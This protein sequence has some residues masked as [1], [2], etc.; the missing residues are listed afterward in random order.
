MGRPEDKDA[1]IL[2]LMTLNRECA[3]LAYD[4]LLSQLQVTSLPAKSDPTAN[5]LIL[6][7][8][9]LES[10]LPSCLQRAWEFC[11]ANR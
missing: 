9:E 5:L 6:H 11:E 2:Y 8:A 3:L 7:A 4:A 10:D 1:D